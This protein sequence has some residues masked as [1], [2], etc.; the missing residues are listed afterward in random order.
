MATTQIK[1]V[2]NG[3]DC[4]SL[5]QTV[6]AIQD[7]PKLGNS[8]FRIRNTWISGGHNQTRVQCFTAA[9]QELFHK[10]NFDLQADEPET[11]GGTD[12]APNPVEHL[13]NAL[14]ACMTT[15]IVAHAALRGIEITQVESLLEGD[16]DLRGFMGLD[17]K[18]PK[19][20]QNIRV[21]FR[22]KTDPNNIPKLRELAEFSPVYN[23]LLQGTHID[24][25]VE[26]K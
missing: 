14:A 20:Y 16:I 10:Y 24:V 18:V 26:P 21:T 1:T 4:E 6:K 15:S 8:T 9:G 5:E 7:D 12:L 19:G 13:L 23:T 22:I 3:I 11:L 25:Q 17:S 2:T